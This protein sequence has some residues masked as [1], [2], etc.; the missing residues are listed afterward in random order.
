MNQVGVGLSG[1]SGTGL[2]VGNNSP[3]ITTPTING[4]TNGSSAA[5]GVVGEVISSAVNDTTINLSSGVAVSITSLPLTEG[6]WDV[7]GWIVFVQ[8]A[9]TTA[10]AVVAAISSVDNTLPSSSTLTIATPTCR[11]DQVSFAANGRQILNISPAIINI[12][13]PATYYL[14]GRLTFS[15]DTATAGGVMIARRRR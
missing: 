12:S 8:A 1:A 9:T 15:V 6:D 10:S 14:V 4:V 13:S 11:I 5:A 3:T 7:W 2:F